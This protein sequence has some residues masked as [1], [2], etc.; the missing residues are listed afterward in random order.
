MSTIT[1]CFN[2]FPAKNIDLNT[3]IAYDRVSASSFKPG[4][5]PEVVHDTNRRTGWAPAPSQVGAQQ[6][7]TITF[8][9]PVDT[10]DQPYLTTELVF[11]YG[12][13]AS[14]KKFRLFLMKGVDDFLER[15]DRDRDPEGGDGVGDSAGATGT[16]AASGPAAS[17]PVRTRPG[18]D[19]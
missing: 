1:P 5:R 12:E 2:P 13:G 11:K 8:A 9:E 14:P 16:A 6:H 4:F 19:P 15:R 17:G 3:A 7:I 10:T 18:Q